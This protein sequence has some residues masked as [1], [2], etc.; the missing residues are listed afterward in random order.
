[1]NAR[2]MDSGWK[3][4]GQMEY[5]YRHIRWTIYGLRIHPNGWRTKGEWMGDL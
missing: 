2:R 3:D 5:R 4:G 1:M